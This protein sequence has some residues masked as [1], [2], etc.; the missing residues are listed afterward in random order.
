MVF[1][2]VLSYSTW[3]FAG[4]GDF[5]MLELGK[6]EHAL[7]VEMRDHSKGRGALTD[8]VVTDNPLA[9]DPISHE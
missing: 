1:F 3:V 8:L 4:Y 9:F 7:S 2:N 5:F 6:G